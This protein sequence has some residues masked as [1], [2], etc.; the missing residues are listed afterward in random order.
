ML[1][2]SDFEEPQLNSREKRG[3]SAAKSPRQKKIQQR[4]VKKKNTLGKKNVQFL[5]KL[6]TLPLQKKKMT[7]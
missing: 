6:R 4:K 5:K 2:D 3:N 7:S 1:R